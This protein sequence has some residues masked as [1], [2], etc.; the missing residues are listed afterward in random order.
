L[1]M[2]DHGLKVVEEVNWGEVHSTVNCGM[3][4]LS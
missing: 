1:Y 4:I 2:Y 3:L